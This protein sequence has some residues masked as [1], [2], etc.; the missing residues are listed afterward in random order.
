MS[1]L[2]LNVPV[3][4][5]KPQVDVK[6]YKGLKFALKK[7]R[8]YETINF[9]PNNSKVKVLTS[10]EICQKIDV[11]TVGLPVLDKDGKP[12][13]KMWMTEKDGVQ[14]PVTVTRTF[15]LQKSK[16]EDGSIK[17][18][19]S[20]TPLAHLWKWMRSIGA[21]TLEEIEGKLGMLTL[22]P[23]KNPDDNRLWLKISD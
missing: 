18:V 23:S 4:E 10:T 13:D 7:P 5:G 17:W 16:Q 1:D 8:R 11:E 22:E 9:W 2:D 15:N 21:K 19:V 6:P 12:T 3:E 20:K 14:V